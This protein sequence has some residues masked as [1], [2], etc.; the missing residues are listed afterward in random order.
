MITFKIIN[1]L[2]GFI[3]VGIVTIGLFIRIE[4]RLSKLETHTIWIRE[5]LDK[6][7]FCN[8]DKKE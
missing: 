3:P 7:T 5:Y 6:H 8:H 1:L 2:Y 4:R